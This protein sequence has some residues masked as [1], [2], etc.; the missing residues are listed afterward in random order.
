MHTE[1]PDGQDKRHRFAGT[2]HEPLT[3]SRSAAIMSGSPVATRDGACPSS[4][5][6]S[7]S[8]S[9]AYPRAKTDLCAFAG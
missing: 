2:I 5:T 8:G 9:L 3:D 7:V 4:T 6:L 1:V